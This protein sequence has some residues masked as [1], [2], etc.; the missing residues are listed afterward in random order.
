MCGHYH[1]GSPQKNNYALQH[2]HSTVLLTLHKEHIDGT[3]F[4]VFRRRICGQYR[5][6]SIANITLRSIPKHT[7]VFYGKRV[8]IYRNSTY[9]LIVIFIC[10]FIYLFI[11]LFIYLTSCKFYGD[12]TSIQTY[13][14]KIKPCSIEINAS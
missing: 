12:D 9:G 14:S 11:N 1:V 13:I 8:V 2:I 10:L 5:G 7:C 6:R 4:A 3:M